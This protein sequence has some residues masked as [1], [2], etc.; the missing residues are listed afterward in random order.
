MKISCVAI[1]LSVVLLVCTARVWA[2]EG[3]SGRI[4][5]LPV[6]PPATAEPGAPDADR[7]ACPQTRYIDCMPTVD[8]PARP[9]CS[10]EYLHWL[11]ENCPEVQVV[12]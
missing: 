11:K 8:K 7:R 6:E 12:Y 1:V 5:V 3:A 2:Q 10:P 9:M 4:G